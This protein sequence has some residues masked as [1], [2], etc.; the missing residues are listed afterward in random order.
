MQIYAVMGSNR[1]TEGDV[2]AFCSWI[3]VQVMAEL[4]EGLPRNKQEQ[5]INQFMSL[6]P[7]KKE[8]VFSPY[9]T[10][11]YMRGR[12]KT[13]TKKAIVERIVEP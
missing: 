4:F 5:A 8:S 1:G 12:V 6:P 2:D 9:Y 10:V 7:H 11:E 3:E 13:A